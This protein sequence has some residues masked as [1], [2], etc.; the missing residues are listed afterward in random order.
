MMKC[1]CSNGTRVG[2]NAPYCRGGFCVYRFKS[3]ADPPL[4]NQRLCACCSSPDTQEN[5]K[6]IS[7]V[8][9]AHYGHH[10]CQFR[11]NDV[12]CL[13]RNEWVNILPCAA[14]RWTTYTPFPTP[15]VTHSTWTNDHAYKPL[16]HSC[17]RVRALTPAGV[18]VTADVERG[19]V[20]VGE[21]NACAR[22]RWPDKRRRFILTVFFITVVFWVCAMHRSCQHHDPCLSNECGVGRRLLQYDFHFQAIS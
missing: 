17:T 8:E 10:I 3:S 4:R 20:G 7:G 18:L 15:Q 12:T 9:P 11:G 22:N 13:R 19:G 6:T 5:T 21:H 16:F 14:D 2:H 1:V